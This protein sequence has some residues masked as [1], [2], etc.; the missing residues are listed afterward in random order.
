[1]V[2]DNVTTSACQWLYVIC[3]GGGLVQGDDVTL[4]V[5]VDQSAAVLVTTQ[6]ATKV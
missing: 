4:T 5:Q 2:P 6:S 3:Y 1:M